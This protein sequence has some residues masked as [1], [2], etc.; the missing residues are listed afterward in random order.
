VGQLAL[1][2][3]YEKWDDFEFGPSAEDELGLDAIG[4]HITNPNVR[5]HRASAL[6]MT[7]FYVPA[8]KG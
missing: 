2:E 4:T 3:K 6:G 7:E 5:W 1:A 8:N